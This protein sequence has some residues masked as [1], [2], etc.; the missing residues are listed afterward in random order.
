MFLLEERGREP[1]NPKSGIQGPENLQ[2]HCVFWTRLLKLRGADGGPVEGRLDL[3][4]QHLLPE[5]PTSGLKSN[6]QLG[7]A[8]GFRVHIQN[9]LY[10]SV[11]H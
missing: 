7:N 1:S 9:R 10:E 11:L 6:D 5:V 3:G 2:L 4:L 8:L